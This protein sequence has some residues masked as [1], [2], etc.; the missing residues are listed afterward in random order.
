MRYIN[1]LKYGTSANAWCTST[2]LRRIHIEPPTPEPTGSIVSLVAGFGAAG[3]V[4]LGLRQCSQ[5][6]S[7]SH[8]SPYFTTPPLPSQNTGHTPIVDGKPTTRT[9]GMY[10]VVR[11]RRR[12]LQCIVPCASKAAVSP[13]QAHAGQWNSQTGGTIEGGCPNFHYL[14]RTHDIRYRRTIVFF[15]KPL[16]WGGSTRH[17]NID[18]GGNLKCSTR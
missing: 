12:S 5:V 4:V 13:R 11:Q 6:R 7:S 10:T 16:T 17:R 1:L 9:A 8:R 14:I 2:G 18:F 3:T 15:S